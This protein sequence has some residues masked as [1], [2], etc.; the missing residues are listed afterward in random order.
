MAGGPC[1]TEAV[2]FPFLFFFFFYP[3]RPVGKST[4]EQFG[5]DGT[6]N[7]HNW[8]VVTQQGPVDK[9]RRVQ[10]GPE[11][12]ERWFWGA[13]KHSPIISQ[14]KANSSSSAVTHMYAASF[15][16]DKTLT[17]Q[18]TVKGKLPL[19]E[20]RRDFIQPRV[21]SFFI[22]YFSISSAEHK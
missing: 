12:E 7:E 19:P 6:A 18:T 22:L 13:S 4:A 17:K 20:G 2:P 1:K 5:D 21:F 14:R 8:Y 11:K 16:K 10:P 9:E 3:L 15:A